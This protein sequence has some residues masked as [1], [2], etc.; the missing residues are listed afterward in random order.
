MELVAPDT[1]APRGVAAVL[2]GDI[3]VALPAAA[4]VV[5]AAAA[6]AT[7]ACAAAAATADG[8]LAP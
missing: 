5:A 6:T 1:F 8:G 3:P 4:A 2:A 7:A